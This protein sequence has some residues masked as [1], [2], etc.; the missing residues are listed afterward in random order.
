MSV[1]ICDQPLDLS[2]AWRQAVAADVGAIASFLG[3]V[4]DA[5]GGGLQ[6]LELEHYPGMTEACIRRMVDE[7]RQRFALTHAEIWHRVGRLPVGEPIVYV[8]TASPHRQA[9]LDG[10]AFLI[11]YLKTQAP[12]WKKEHGP[13]GAEWVDARE[14]DDAALARWG[15]NLSNAA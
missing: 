9:S 12:F 5:P 13:W 10:C 15:L 11:D 7:A 1:H 2:E 8:L 3:V 14:A 6:A 4:R